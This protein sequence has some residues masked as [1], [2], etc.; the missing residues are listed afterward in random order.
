LAH[1]YPE[2]LQRSKKTRNTDKKRKEED[3][4][5]SGYGGMWEVEP[6]VGRL[7][8]GIPHGMDRIRCLGN[9]VVPQQVYPILKAIAEIE[10]GC[11]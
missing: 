1:T 9:A 8:N 5:S 2:R 11:S 3:K 7:V 10:R 4:L 6:R